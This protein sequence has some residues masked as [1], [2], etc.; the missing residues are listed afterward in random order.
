MDATSREKK[1]K[2]IFQKVKI[3]NEDIIQKL[4]DQGAILSWKDKMFLLYRDYPLFEYLLQQSNID[5]GYTTIF[6]NKSLRKVLE[7]FD[8]WIDSDNTNE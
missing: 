6:R 3:M 4:L 1:N 2:K 7:F 8:D 5:T